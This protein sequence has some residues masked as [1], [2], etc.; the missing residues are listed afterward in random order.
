MGMQ[1]YGTVI[2]TFDGPSTRKFSFVINKKVVK[3]GQFVQLTTEEGKLIGRVAD[4]IKTNRYFMRPESVKEYESSGKSMEQIFPVNDWEFLMAEVTPLGVFNE[5][6]FQDT[7][8]PPSPGTRVMEPDSLLLQKFFGMDTEGLHLGNFSNHDLAVK[9]NPTRLL[10]K[11]LAI[12]ALSGAGKSYLTSVLVEELL[13]RKPEEGLAI[14]II[15]P[16]GEYASFADD[17]I[18][19]AKTK[20]FGSRDIRIGLPN[21]SHHNFAEFVPKLSPV[22]ARQLAKVLKGMRG[23]TKYSIREVIERLEKDESIKAATKDILVSTLLDM[24]ETGVFGVTDFPRLE[25]LARQGEITVIDLSETTSMKTKQIITTY[26]ARK[27]FKFRRQGVIP[28]FLL[29]LEEAHQFVPE[30]ASR[31]EALSRGVL[32]TIAREGRKFHASLCLISQRPKR[33]STTILSQCNTNIILRLTNPYDLKHVEETSEGI[34][35]DVVRQISSLRV[36]TALIVGEAVNFPLFMDIRKRASKES[37]KGMP[38]ERAA[39]NYYEA[40]QQKKKDAKAFM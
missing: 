20:I 30:G 29:I 11:H 15:D 2:S 9:I 14:I 36:G 38:L 37:E 12:L 28:P 22:Q 13:N 1:E 3:R 8:F 25:D 39:R 6:R 40:M 23:Q 19:S 35:R 18:F 7:L 34:T 32:T 26:I 17:P 27:L 5:N 24:Q 16:H 21:L 33:L 4:V 10:Q 31:E